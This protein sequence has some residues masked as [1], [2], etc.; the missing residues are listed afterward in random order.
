MCLKFNFMNEFHSLHVFCF[1]RALRETDTIEVA[2]ECN[3]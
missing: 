3:K 2:Y 1:V